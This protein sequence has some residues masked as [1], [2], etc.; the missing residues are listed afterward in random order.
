MLKFGA[1][2][3]FAEVQ[4]FSEKLSTKEGNILTSQT[5]QGILSKEKSQEESSNRTR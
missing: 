3:L 2:F 1:I 5:S 4:W